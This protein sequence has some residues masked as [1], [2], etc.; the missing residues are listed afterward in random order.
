MTT[1]ENTKPLI[2]FTG[3]GTGGHVFP[4]L[5]VIEELRNRGYVNIVWIGS[6]GGMEEDIVKRAGIPYYGVPSGK[7]RRYFSLRNFTDFF[8]IFGGFLKSRRILK[9]L[10]PKVLFSKGGFVSVPPVAAA[11]GLKIPCLTH[12][13]DADPGLATRI[14]ARSVKKIFVPYEETLKYFP[15]KKNVMVTGNPVRRIFYEGNKAKGKA[16]FGIKNDKPLILVLGG[17]SGAQQINGLIEAILPRLTERYNVVHQMGIKNFRESGLPG[18]Y[19]APFFREEL[20]DI[21]AAADLAVSRAGAG[22]LWELAASGTPAVLIPLSTGS[23]RG[24]QIR[25]GEIFEK[26]GMARVLSGKDAE[27]E[28]L[29]NLINSL[30]DSADKLGDMRKKASE[31]ASGRAAERLAEEI[32]KEL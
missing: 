14:N 18:Y 12:E 8:K 17:S 25:N 27:P 16:F 11:K 2:A 13:S 29:L 32:I 4:G 20:A 30:F 10:K 26:A 1:N 28:T 24:D 31:L 23:S 22:S 21:L 9:K 19:P 6:R 3:G 5:A 7:L 15:G